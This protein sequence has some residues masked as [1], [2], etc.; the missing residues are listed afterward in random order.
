MRLFWESILKIG[1]DKLFLN[2]CKYLLNKTEATTV[3]K[4]ESPA[5]HY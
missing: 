1:A 4:I 2:G 5:G 3:C